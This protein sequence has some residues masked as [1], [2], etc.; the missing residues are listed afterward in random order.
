MKKRRFSEEKIIYALRQAESGTKVI[1]ICR[2]MG[3]S[4]NTFYVWKRKYQGLGITE[5]KKLKMLTDENDRLKKLV[6]DLTLDKH[7]LQEVVEKKL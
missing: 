4:T 3:I 1:D 5:A 6:A 7:I 2:K